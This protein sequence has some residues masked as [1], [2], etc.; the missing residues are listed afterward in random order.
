MMALLFLIPSYAYWCSKSSAPCQSG[1]VSVLCLIWE[2]ITL[3]HRSHGRNSILF[4]PTLLQHQL[5]SRSPRSPRRRAASHHFPGHT[6]LM[7]SYS[8]SL[9]N[10][11]RSP[12]LCITTIVYLWYFSELGNTAYPFNSPLIAYNGWW[13]YEVCEAEQMWGKRRKHEARCALLG[14]IVKF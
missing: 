5:L 7:E 11:T 9:C 2:S 12:S 4:L 8:H 3:L 13:V 10:W 1:T 14:D 6:Y